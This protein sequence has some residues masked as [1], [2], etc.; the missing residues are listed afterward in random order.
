VLASDAD[1]D[2]DEAALAR[3]R[4]QCEELVLSMWDGY[5]NQLKHIEMSKGV[6]FGRTRVF[7]TR[8]AIVELE[9][10]REAR[11]E[12]MDAACV[13]IQTLGRGGVA[14]R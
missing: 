11:Y 8:D 9:S 7:C 10:L 14:R 13:T 2:V 1:L 3:Q 5:G 4:K 6:V 12:A